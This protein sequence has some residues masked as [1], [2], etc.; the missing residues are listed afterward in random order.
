[1][2]IQ[3]SKAV[4]TTKPLKVLSYGPTWSGK[5]L[6]SLYLAVGI[7]SNIRNCTIE[8]AYKHIL[9]VDTEYNRGTLYAHIG[10]YNHINV[11]A[12]YDTDKLI[13]IIKEINIDPNIDVIII[14]S[15]TH[16]WT[17]EGGILDQKATKDR[18]NPKSNTYTNWLEF[19]T[20]FNKMIDVILASPK[21]ILSTARA[22]S[23]TVV[24]KNDA[25]R[26]VIKTYGLKP[27]LRDDID[28]EFDIVFNIDKETH[29]LLVDKGVTGMQPV[30]EMATP[31]LGIDL[32]ELF[33]KDSVMPELT[34]EDLIERIKRTI[35]SNNMIQFM[36]LKLS[37]RKLD[38]LTKDQL[39][40]IEDDLTEE[41]KK[42]QLKK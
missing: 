16:F 3:Y 22:K 10:E 2:A 23:D 29:S 36:Q 41:I 32:F 12:P 38:D 35:I 30:Y 14:D 20:K 33:N 11:S 4:K 21:H 31:Q 19:T 6:S 28:F 27:E 13:G 15:L 9:V 8:E 7:I 37:G 5:T 17:K 40:S 34:K 39:L 26:T 1:M 24:T 25:D 42:K 18:E